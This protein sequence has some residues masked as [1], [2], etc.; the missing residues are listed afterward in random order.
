MTR[1]VGLEPELPSLA[2]GEEIG[3]DAKQ[4]AKKKKKV[5]M[6]E[7]QEHYHQQANRKK[8]ELNVSEEE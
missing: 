5:Q 1:E 8:Q 2:N 3:R 7:T 6:G 4:T